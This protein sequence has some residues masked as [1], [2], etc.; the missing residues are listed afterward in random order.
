MTVS[1]ERMIEGII[2]TL[3]SDVIPNVADPHGRG[4][5]IGVI[6]L[7]SNL[8]DRLEWAR[9][10]LVES[11]R[12]K[13]ELLAAIGALLPGLPA[14]PPSDSDGLS[15]NELIDLKGRLDAA[16]GDAIALAAKLKT[17]PAEQAL[18]LMTKHL[19]DEQ[20]REMKLTRKPLF[21]EMSRGTDTRER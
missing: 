10:P 9:G 2:A 7:L 17:E 1:L 21:A 13:A 4:Q 12:E 6:D 5:A 8:G 20:A 3:R 16:I 11:M 14:A 19:H 18:A 15:S